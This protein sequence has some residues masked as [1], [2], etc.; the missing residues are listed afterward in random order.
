MVVKG[1]L[2]PTAR[3]RPGSLGGPLK[4]RIDRDRGD[5]CKRLDAPAAVAF[6][7]REAVNGR[8]TSSWQGRPSMQRSRG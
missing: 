3:K 2:R 5:G 6:V 7:E 8:A 4:L 1:P